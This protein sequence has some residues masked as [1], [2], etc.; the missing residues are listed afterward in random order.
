MY[1]NNQQSYSLQKSEFVHYNE[2]HDNGSDSNQNGHNNDY[3]LADSVSHR[4]YLPAPVT[5]DQDPRLQQ[6]YHPN[7]NQDEY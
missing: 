3:N 2:G 1:F 5:Y 7:Y 6:Q 4:N